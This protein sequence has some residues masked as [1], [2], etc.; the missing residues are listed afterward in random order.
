ME[1]EEILQRLD[2]FLDSLN[3]K[4]NVMILPDGDGDGFSAAVIASKAVETLTTK[5]PAIRF[6]YKNS[7]GIPDEVKKEIVEKNFN[8]LIMLDYAIDQSPE[9]IKILED[10]CRILIID[11]HKIYNDLNSDKTILIKPQFFSK[12]EPSKYNTSKLAFDLFS[13]KANIK[14]LDWVAGVGII[15]DSSVDQWKSFM[16]EVN[17]SY[18]VGGKG[19]YSNSKLG[20]ISAILSGIESFAPQDFPVYFEK[21][22]H[23]GHPRDVMLAQYEQY[24]KDLSDEVAYWLSKT[25][26]KAQIYPEEELIY[27]EISPKHNIKSGLINKIAKEIFPDRTVIVVMHS[28]DPEYIS[29]S[30]RRS[31][32]KIKTN[33]LLE[34][35]IEGLENASA[36][37][38][39]PASAGRILKKDLPKFK[40]KLLEVVK[41]RSVR[42]E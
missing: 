15:A 39:V 10:I 29:F 40:E 7:R 12:I 1:K 16:Q 4:D 42:N 26:E 35:S 23:A 2:S 38:H 33:E 25:N 37:G 20:D 34:K 14:S 21:F 19:K 36:G 32:F 6:L 11:H 17:D 5:K 3:E 18:D 9:V 8:V 13:R 27:Y 28:S 41:Q 31:D 22:L 24:A 30:A